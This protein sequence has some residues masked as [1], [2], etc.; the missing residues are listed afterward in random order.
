MKWIEIKEYNMEGIVRKEYNGKDPNKG[1]KWKGAKE[2]NIM[3]G[4]QIKE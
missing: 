4:I 2:R 1:I 3:K